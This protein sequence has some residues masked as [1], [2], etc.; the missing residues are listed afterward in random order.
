MTDVAIAG[1]GPEARG[2]CLLFYLQI[3]PE[4]HFLVLYTAAF[5]VGKTV[6]M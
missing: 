4:A 3:C 6:R 2:H 1:S 5:P